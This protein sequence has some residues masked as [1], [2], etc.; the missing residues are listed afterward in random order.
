MSLGPLVLP[1]YEDSE[2]VCLLVTVPSGCPV[3]FGF[4]WVPVVGVHVRW[5]EAFTNNRMVR[6]W[7]FDQR[8]WDG[9]AMGYILPLRTSEFVPGRVSVISLS[10]G[11]LSYRWK[12]EAG[13]I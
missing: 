13:E 12:A 3:A 11:C 5:V 8:L 9:R 4:G 7:M 1:S 2:L 6:R 10:F